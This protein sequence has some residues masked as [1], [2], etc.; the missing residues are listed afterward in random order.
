LG[1]FY[2]FNGEIKVGSSGFILYET[3]PEKF[4]N[5]PITSSEVIDDGKKKIT[6]PLYFKM[7]FE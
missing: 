2:I 4:K 6:E 3:N 5:I 7:F 1:G